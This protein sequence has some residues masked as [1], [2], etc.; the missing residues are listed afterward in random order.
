[1]LDFIFRIL[2]ATFKK[3]NNAIA[4]VMRKICDLYLLFGLDRIQ[5]DKS[6]F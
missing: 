1:M 5:I 4:Y 6:I 3:M 2:F